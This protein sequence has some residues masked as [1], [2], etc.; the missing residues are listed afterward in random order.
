M[1]KRQKAQ[2]EKRE[3]VSHMLCQILLIMHIIVIRKKVMGKKRGE[4]RKEKKNFV[5]ISSGTLFC[6]LQRKELEKD[7][8]EK[9]ASK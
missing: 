2:D 3:K 1:Q 9:E 6:R 7:S 4:K 5:V 8:G